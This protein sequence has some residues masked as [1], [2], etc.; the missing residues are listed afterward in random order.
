MHRQAFEFCKGVV[1]VIRQTRRVLEVGSYN[2]NGSVRELF[3]FSEYFGI[4]VRPGRGVDHVADLAAMTDEQFTNWSDALEL[5]DVVISTETLEHVADPS[6]L[7]ER[8]RAMCAAGGV[9]VITAA[10]PKRE[11]HS[12]LDGGALRPGEHYR[13][14]SEAEL[15]EWLAP[16]AVV[17]TAT[18][19]REDV[20]AFAVV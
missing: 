3:P 1:P 15:R 10:G 7:V 16:C 18:R 4:D 2:V 8:M 14:I 12:G 19:E 6:L 20:Y 11:P 5:F 13:G 9:V 17:L